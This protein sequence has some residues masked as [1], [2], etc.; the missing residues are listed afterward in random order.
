MAFTHRLI[1]AFRVAALLHQHQVRK[2]SNV[3]YVT[4]LMAVAALVG[5]HGG[6]EA[7][8]IAALLHDAVED[9]GGEATAHQILTLFGP[10]VAAIVAGCTDTAITPKPPWKARKEAFIHRLA[11]ADRSVRLVTAADKL[12]NIRSLV[13][14]LR[15]HGA[16]VWRKFATGRDGTLWYYRAVAQALH[17]HFEHPI[18]AELDAALAALA[19]EDAAHPPIADAVV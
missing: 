18:L 9:Q 3:P 4:H 10:E 6:T 8:V 5:E 12:H 17:A 1:D 16:A 13:I 7:E 15:Q 14:D 11:S 19:I 2:G